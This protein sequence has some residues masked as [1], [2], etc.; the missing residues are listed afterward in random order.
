MRNVVIDK[1]LRECSADEVVFVHYD[2]H[3]L[4]SEGPMLKPRQEVAPYA[5]VV[6]LALPR[7]PE[8]MRLLVELRDLPPP[9]DDDDGDA[10]VSTLAVHEMYPLAKFPVSRG[11]RA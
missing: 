6:G 8:A 11:G 2:E 1:L 3:G 5:N 4:V 9:E 7:E 10:P